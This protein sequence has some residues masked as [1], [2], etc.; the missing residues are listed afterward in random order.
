MGKQNGA[1]VARTEVTQYII[2]YIKT[3]NLQWAENRKIIKPDVPLRNLLGV[4]DGME[5][6]YF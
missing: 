1:E 2:S 3:K 6:T 4:D 5:V